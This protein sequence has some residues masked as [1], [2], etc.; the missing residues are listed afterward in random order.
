MFQEIS[1]M[2]SSQDGT[3]NCSLA[4]EFVETA[5]ATIEK[6]IINPD[7]GKS[8]CQETVVEKDEDPVKE[9]ID[10]NDGKKR[11]WPDLKGENVEIAKATIL[12]ERPDLNVDVIPEGTPWTRE[13]RINGVRLSV[14]EK[15]QVVNVPVIG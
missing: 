8:S 4:K 6:E 15:G 9:N 7:H 5:K 2:S 1:N 11:S 3:K 12:R 14:N 13:F 10:F